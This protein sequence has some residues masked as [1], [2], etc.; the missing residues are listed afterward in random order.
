MLNIKITTK[1]VGFSDHTVVYLIV[2]YLIM[3]NNC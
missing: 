2:D 1:K 3:F